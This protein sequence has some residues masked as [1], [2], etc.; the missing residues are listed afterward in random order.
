MLETQQLFWRNAQNRNERELYTFAPLTIT[1]GKEVLIGEGLKA[2]ESFS[3][4]RILKP[5]GSFYMQDDPA[6]PAN[7]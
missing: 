5:Q 2:N 4:Y 6:Q 3:K 1:K 7:P